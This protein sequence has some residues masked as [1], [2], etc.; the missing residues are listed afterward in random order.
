MNISNKR[1]RAHKATSSYF[2]EGNVYMDAS[3]NQYRCIGKHLEKITNG[4]DCLTLLKPSPK[5]FQRL[6]SAVENEY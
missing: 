5:D 3:G 6:Y 2:Q 4:N 1:K